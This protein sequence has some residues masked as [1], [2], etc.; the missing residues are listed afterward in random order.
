MHKDSTTD[1]IAV[2]VINGDALG[3]KYESLYQYSLDL[4]N[5]NGV[6]KKDKN[7]GVMIVLCVDCPE[8]YIQNGLGIEPR[9]SDED[10]G[11]IVD[12]MI[13]YFAVNDYYNGLLIGVIR[14][15]DHLK[16]NR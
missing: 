15:A 10:T 6:G 7:N 5:F 4:A 1:E 2:V 13:D 8:I 16:G 3:F 14:V 9:L 12:E 11:L